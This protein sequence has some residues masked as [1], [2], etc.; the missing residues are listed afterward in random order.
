M[1]YTTIRIEGAILS[2]DILDRIEQGNIS[3]QL[4][5]D[6]GLDAKIRVKDEIAR[7]WAD[8]QDLWRIFN[9]QREKVP[10]DDYGTSETRRYWILP[11]LGL[12]GYDVQLSRAESINGKS[13]AVSHRSDNLDG[14]PVH[15]MGFNDSLD[16]KRDTSG[17]Q[18]SPHALVQEYI[19]V[20]EHYLYGIVTNGIQLRLLRDSSRLIKLSLIEFDLQTM[21]DEEHFADFAIMYRLLHVSRMPI[22]KELGGDSL[23]EKYHQDALESG[24]RIRNGLSDAVELSIRSLANG[25]LEHPGNDHLRERIGSRDISPLDY[26]QYQLRLIY[27]ILF[28]LVI[29]ERNLVFPENSGRDKRDIYREYYSISRLRQ[30]CGKPYILEQRHHDLW[31]GLKHT[32]RLFETDAKGGYL[33]IKPLAGDLF[34]PNAL[35]VLNQCHL[36]NRVLLGCIKNLSVFQNKTTGQITRVN[37]AALNVEEFGSVYE[38]LL[39]FDPIVSLQD[40]HYQ[41]DLKKGDERSSSGSHYTPDEMVQPLIKHSLDHIIRERLKSADSPV[42]KE[43]ALLSIK[44]CDA[45]CGSGHILLNV[46]RRIGMALAKVRTGEDQP[47]PKPLRQSVRDVIQFCIYGVDK[48][49]LAVDLCKVALWLEAHNPGEPLN[50]LDHHIKCGDAIVGLAHKEELEKGIPDEAFKKMP[51]DDKNIRAQFAKQNRKQRATACKREF[52]Y[53][54]SQFS[55]VE[56]SFADVSQIF[57]S[58]NAL[59]ETSINQIQ[60]KRTTYQTMISGENWRLLKS[61]CDIQTA[62][63]FIPKTLEN[64]GAIVTDDMFRQYMSGIR[65]SADGLSAAAGMARKNRFFHWFLEFPEV[66]AKGGFDCILGNPP[67]L[68]GQKLSGMFGQ[69]FLEYVKYAYAPAGSC[70]LVTYFFRRIFTIIRPGG[71]Q[72]L[73]STNTIAQGAAREGGLAVILSQGGAIH[74]AVRSMKWPGLAAV[75]V[76]LVGIYRGKWNGL[77]NLNGKPVAQITFYL[78]DAEI[79]GNPYPLIQNADKSFQGSIVLGKGFVLEPHEAM[80]LIEKNPKNKDVLFPYLN[81]EDLNTSP[82]QSPSRWVINFFDWPEEKCR[83]EYRDCFEIVEW[84]VKPE[85]QLLKNNPDG[86]RRKKNWWLYGRNPI[87]LYRTIE[88]LERVLLIA[89]VSKTVAVDFTINDK[90]LDAKLVVFSLDRYKDFSILQSSFH[91]NWAWKYCTTM[92]ADLSYTPTAIFQTLPFP[93]NPSW[94]TEFALERIGATY[95]ENRRRLMRNAQI[96]LT[97]TYNQFHNPR[98]FAIDDDLPEKEIEKQFGKE[99]LYLWNHLHRTLGTCNFNQAVADIAHLRRLHQEM[100]ETVLNA[101]GWTDICLAHDFYEVDYLPENDRIRY[102]ISPTA[103]KEILNR[104]L[105]LNHEIHKRE[106]QEGEA[107]EAESQKIHPMDDERQ[108]S[109]FDN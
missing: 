70:D 106:M 87:S 91:Y 65:I 81:G 95:H 84:L 97:K 62:Q 56:Q 58:F 74:F 34:G 55:R 28:L 54:H 35:G 39:E 68:G 12:L 42:E 49:P 64:S 4:A 7:S 88:P 83:E 29:E 17:A 105:K 6:F 67:F 11:L 94:E 77:C 101:Y 20:T 40:G 43:Q 82:D 89:Q 37:Y 53:R 76:S 47:S 41:F 5:T 25:F 102:T 109:L 26:Y 78:D 15:V 51:D 13:Y 103:R 60:E 14:F 19:N 80:N 92:K 2:A 59:P 9:R 48:N 44:V 98:L 16:K 69:R 63:F 50:F 3:G 72:A 31:I 104:L 46:A 85:R 23:I 38:G 24:S 71:F 93:Q 21:M 107:F 30:L 86:I 45:A 8:A 73:I 99:T 52:F 27:R 66:F 100:D 18:M 22:K 36:P 79:T 90:V 32:F 10:A 96:G 1:K 75:E 33:G 108:L 61:L 57:S